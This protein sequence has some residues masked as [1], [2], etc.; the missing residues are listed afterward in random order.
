MTALHIVSHNI[1][2]VPM[3]ARC[4]CEWPGCTE[5]K[6]AT[7]EAHAAHTLLHAGAHPANAALQPEPQ[8]SATSLEARVIATCVSALL[9]CSVSHSL[10]LFCIH[11]LQCVLVLSLQNR[12]CL[13]FDACGFV[14]I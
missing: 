5:G 10:C 14:T 2:H 1:E 9:S 12:L 6:A 3:E 11:I 8:A 7:D 13:R 4:Y